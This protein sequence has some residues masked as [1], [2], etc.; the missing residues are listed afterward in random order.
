M[1]LNRSPVPANFLPQNNG[2]HQVAM[3]GAQPLNDYELV[4]GF[5]DSKRLPSET[6]VVVG[7]PELIAAAGWSSVLGGAG[8]GVPTLL[9]MQF[10]LSV[11]QTIFD[12]GLAVDGKELGGASFTVVPQ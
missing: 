6:K 12:S 7:T 2:G 9:G 3:N 4:V 10:F 11:T 5:S 1:W 8:N